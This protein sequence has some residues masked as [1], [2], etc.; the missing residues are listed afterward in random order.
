M[1]LPLAS[2]SILTRAA[3]AACV[4]ATGML[5]LPEQN[6]RIPLK[7]FDPESTPRPRDPSASVE[8]TAAA[9]T[10]SLEVPAI[11]SGE[12]RDNKIL[13]QSLP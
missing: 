8:S 4:C 12:E 1:K 6:C 13:T 5:L 2:I 9:M 10:K 7:R 11:V 3:L